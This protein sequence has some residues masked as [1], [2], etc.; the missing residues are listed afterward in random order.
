MENI[1]AVWISMASAAI[2]SISLGWNIYRDIVLKPRIRIQISNS[3]V[4]ADTNKHRLALTIINIGPSN[5]TIESI[6]ARKRC[7]IH[8]NQSIGWLRDY[9]QSGKP[10]PATLAVCERNVTLFSKDQLDKIRN[11]YNQLGVYDA[12][13]RYHWCSVRKLKKQLHEFDR[14]ENEGWH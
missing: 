6:I 3:M 11:K 10:F 13:G 12:F 4:N 5:I 8:R 7:F 14:F 9:P 1:S 2:A